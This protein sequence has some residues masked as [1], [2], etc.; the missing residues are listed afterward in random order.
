[1]ANFSAVNEEYCRYFGRYPPSRSCISVA[2]PDGAG[3]AV[4][5]VFLAGSYSS[6]I[7]GKVIF[8]EVA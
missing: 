6:I 3:V 7:G 4:D 8:N 1:M 5:A 2:M